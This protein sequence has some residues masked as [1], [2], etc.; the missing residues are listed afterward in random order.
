MQKGHDR[1]L[2]INEEFY[3]MNINVGGTMVLLWIA[4]FL[5]FSSEFQIVQAFLFQHEYIH[6]TTLNISVS[7]AKGTRRWAIKRDFSLTNIIAGTVVLLRVDR[8][9]FLHCLV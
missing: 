1:G 6:S 5:E 9:L 4:R 2:A 7:Y 3:Q 8:M